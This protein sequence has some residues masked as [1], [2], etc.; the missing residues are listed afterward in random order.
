MPVPKRKTSRPRKRKRQASNS[1]VVLPQVT[2]CP[3]CAEPYVPHRVCPACGFYKGR[4]VV[5]VSAGA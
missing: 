1:R 4:Q 2:T 5:S 3:Q